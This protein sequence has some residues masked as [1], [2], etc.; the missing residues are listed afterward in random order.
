VTFK[1][2]EISSLLAPFFFKVLWSLL[3][4]LRKINLS[5]EKKSKS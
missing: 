4:Y 3:F 2:K 1:T 5:K